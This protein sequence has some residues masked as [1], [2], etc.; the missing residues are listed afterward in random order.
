MQACS[1]RHAGTQLSA[2]E[3]KSKKFPPIK[4][5]QA[6]SYPRKEKKSQKFPPRERSNPGLHD[7]RTKPA[8]LR[9]IVEYVEPA[10]LFRDGKLEKVYLT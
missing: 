10:S 3:K 7:S 8:L 9:K 5:M 4:F 6:C 2:Q 1:E